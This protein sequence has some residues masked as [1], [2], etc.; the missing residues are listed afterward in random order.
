[1]NKTIGVLAHVD[2]GKTI[3]SEGFLYHTN[4]MF[5]SKGSGYILLRDV[6]QELMH[7]IWYHEDDR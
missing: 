2:A 5:C 1:M 7:C 3:F 4:T 6:A